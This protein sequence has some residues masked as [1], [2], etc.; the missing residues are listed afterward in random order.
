MGNALSKMTLFIPSF[1]QYNDVLLHVNGSFGREQLQ[2]EV[3]QYR[4][5]HRSA[6]WLFVPMDDTLGFAAARDCRFTPH[7]LT[8]DYFVLTLWLSEEENRLPDYATHIV[9][10]ECIVFNGNGDVLM[11]RERYGRRD[12]GWKFCSGNVESGEFIPQAAVRETQEETGLQT[13]FVAVLGCGN[14]LNVRF[15][16]SELFFIVLLKLL[17]D[18]SEEIC[19]EQEELDDAVWMPPG[20]ARTFLG[21]LE[22]KCLRSAQYGQGMLNFLPKNEN[23][24]IQ[25]FYV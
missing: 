19:I 16:C 15:N 2:A 22:A 9:R 6:I 11:V 12:R 3:D 25:G 14:R 4:H 20:Q 5:E 1:N 24:P 7:H 17:P 8:K 10:V 21:T 13:S 18:T 23:A